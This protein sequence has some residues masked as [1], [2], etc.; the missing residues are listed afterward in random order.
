M[1]K[2]FVELYIIQDL[3]RQLFYCQ[4][5]LIFLMIQIQ[6]RMILIY[7]LNCIILGREFLEAVPSLIV[8]LYQMIPFRQHYLFLNYICQNNLQYCKILGQ[9]MT[10]FIIPTVIL[11]RILH[12]IFKSFNVLNY[13]VPDLGSKIYF[14]QAF[15]QV[16]IQQKH[17][18]SNPYIINHIILDQER[19]AYP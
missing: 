18:S 16:F 14:D 19:N 7:H 4:Q 1:I 3:G 12:Q 2:V 17:H 11:F 15:Q 5:V 6:M 9:D 10:I 8:V 13:N